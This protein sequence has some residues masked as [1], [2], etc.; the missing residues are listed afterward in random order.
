MIKWAKDLTPSEVFIIYAAMM[1]G[2]FVMTAFFPNMPMLAWGG[3]LT[4]GA[5]TF[6]AQF[7]GSRKADRD[8]QVGQQRT[9]QFR[10]KYNPTAQVSK[11]G[12][13]DDVAV[14][15]Q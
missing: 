5:T 9:E 14:T 15:K 10:L 7:Y 1:L 11:P 4:T 8:I 6:F 13:V 12:V 2:A 3:S